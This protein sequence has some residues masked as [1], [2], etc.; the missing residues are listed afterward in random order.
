MVVH[1]PTYCMFGAKSNK[2]IQYHCFNNVAI[3]NGNTLFCIDA[4]KK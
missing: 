2:S 3:S 4:G 1:L